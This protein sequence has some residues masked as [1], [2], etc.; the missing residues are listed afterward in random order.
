MKVRYDGASC[1]HPGSGLDLTQGELEVTEAQ[2]E[3]LG[4]LVTK[5]DDAPARRKRA[6]P[7][8]EKE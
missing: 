6:E 3:Q 2:A 1:Y 5:V 7:A 8:P 4:A